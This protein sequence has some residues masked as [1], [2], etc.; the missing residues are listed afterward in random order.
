MTVFVQQNIIEE[1]KDDM[2][3]YAADEDKARIPE[4][5]ESIPL[6]LLLRC[7]LL[8]LGKGEVAEVFV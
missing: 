4:G 3:K 2:V 8:S 7:C 1:Y 5:F 6:P